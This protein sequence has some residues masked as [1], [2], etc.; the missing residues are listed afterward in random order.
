MPPVPFILIADDYAITGGVSSAI[1]ELLAKERL[2]GTSAMTNQP[3]WP[4]LA[5]LLKPFFDCRDLGL[6]LTL[7]LGSPLGAMPDLAPEGQLPSLNQILARSLSGQ[8]SRPEITS[9]IMNQIAA[10]ETQ[11]GRLP[12]FIDGH[13]HVHI[14]P[15]VRSA[16]FEAVERTKAGWRP[17]LRD[18]SDSL[19]TIV[20]RGVS[21]GKSLFLAVL[22]QGF[23]TSARKRGFLVNDSFSGAS[24]FKAEGHFRK[25]FG[26]FLLVSGKRHLVMC[27]PGHSDSELAALDPV[28]DAR[29][30]EYNFFNSSSFETLLAR[31]NMRVARFG[32]ID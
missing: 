6:H 1:L 17:W 11:T 8:L 18:P 9:E 19:G 32:D 25:D 31:M 2:S 10:F 20:A 4:A 13:Q 3:G 28:T 7:T 30:E 24:D 16:L 15:T 27:H 26:R 22:A 21:V 14:L 29:D 12:D 23:R 5:P